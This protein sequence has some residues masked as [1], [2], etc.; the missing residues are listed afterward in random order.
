M[1]HST[2]KSIWNFRIKKMFQSCNAIE[3]HFLVKGSLCY[4]NWSRIFRNLDFED[5]AAGAKTDNV[6]PLKQA[7]LQQAL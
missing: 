5:R 2:P 7:L 4:K 1:D 3:L 6:T